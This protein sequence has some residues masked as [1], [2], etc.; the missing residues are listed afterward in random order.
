[1]SGENKVNIKELEKFLGKRV[2]I[3][4]FDDEVIVGELHKTREEQFKN[5]PNLYFPYK[6]YFLINPQSFLFRGYQVKKIK[7]VKNDEN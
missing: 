4:L 6:Y 5:N 7:E 2:E 1:M 3:K